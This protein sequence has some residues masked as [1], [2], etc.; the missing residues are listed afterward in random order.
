MDIGIKH[1]PLPLE[2]AALTLPERF[3]VIDVVTA[4]GFP[5]AAVLMRHQETKVY[6]IWSGGAVHSVDQRKAARYAGQF[7]LKK[8]TEA[9][10]NTLKKIGT[11]LGIPDRTIWDW[12]RGA[13]TP[14]DYVLSLIEE[15]YGV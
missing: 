15:H 3:D 8:I 10:G 4:D 11:D 12:S 7:R 2:M 1:S 9:T 6:I 13:A 5:I 14:P